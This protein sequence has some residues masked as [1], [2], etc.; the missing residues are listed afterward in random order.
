MKIEFL[1]AISDVTGSMTLVSDSQRKI[2]I[3]CGL[4]QG[5]EGVVEKNRRNLGFEAK[6]IDAIILSH[7][8]LDH[9][10]FIPR[11]VKLGFRGP[12]FCTEPTKKLALL[13]MNDSA[14]I[15][16]KN[17]FNILHS[18]YETTH[19]AIAAGLF[20]TKK[21]HEHFD[22]CG[23]DIEFIPA[24][25]ILGAASIVMTG[26]KKIVFSGDL[27]RT[28]D[29]MLNPPEKCPEADIIV[30][31]S[32]YG[33]T[34]RKSIL[35]DD[36]KKFLEHVKKESKVGII[37]SFA[38]ARA[39]LLMTLIYKYFQDHPEEKVR[40]VVDGPMMTSATG[41]YMKFSDQTKVSDDLKSAV[42]NIEVIDQI[43]EWNS[44][45]KKN[46]PL[47][48]ITSSGMV[49]GGRIWRYLENWQTDTNACLFLP[50]YQGQ[51]TA[52]RA[53]KE[54]TK[55]VHDEEGNVIEWSGEVITSDAF[56]SHADQR[57]LLAWLENVKKDVTI[58][59]NHGE[60]EAKVA[61]QKKL[62]EVG[63]SDVQIGV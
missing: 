25:H 47:I 27:G 23:V 46:G 19:V 16:K 63:Y 62:M 59:L 54:G 60:P 36:L 3:D 49:T 9:S 42:E 14:Q 29:I 33:G 53:L 56:S 32:T 26:E 44:L 38:V 58:Y 43:R 2:L 57:D 21:Y 41:I 40:V 48:V 12:I 17:E 35:E 61:L 55:T 8:H 24:G 1:G 52:G 50:G 5:P 13:I 37:A 39:Q 30:M 15:F 34:V 51:G 11:L 45:K 10:G 31:E 22:V 20:K 18:F 28:D 6:D 4:Y 7:A